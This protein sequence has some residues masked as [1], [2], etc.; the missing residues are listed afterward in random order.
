MLQKNRPNKTN[1]TWWNW[2]C[3]LTQPDHWTSW[4]FPTKNFREGANTTIWSNYSDLGPQ[5][6]AIVIGWNIFYF[7]KIQISETR[8]KQWK[9]PK[10]Y[11][12]RLEID[13]STF[14][15]NTSD[16]YQTCWFNGSLSLEGSGFWKFSDAPPPQ[17]E[18]RATSGDFNHY[19]QLTAWTSSCSKDYG[20]CMLML[21]VR[22]PASC[23]VLSLL[24]DFSLEYSDFPLLFPVC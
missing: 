7:R 9:I 11:F 17:C 22:S 1:P 19:V 16:L 21:F 15:E 23:Q 12:W 2:S 8:K 4:I 6:V 14:C 18:N 20:R 5:K 24:A 10:D 13:A 3:K